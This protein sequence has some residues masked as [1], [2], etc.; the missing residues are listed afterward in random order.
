M[1]VGDDF[2]LNTERLR[3][4]RWREEDIDYA[5]MLWGDYRVTRLIDARGQLSKEQ[6]SER[7]A[8]EIETEREYAVQYWPVF[9]LNQDEFIG[10][11]GLRPYDLQDNIYEIG[12]HICA[13]HWGQGFA[14]EAAQAIISYAFNALQANSLF[15]GHNPNN[16]TSQR[17]LQKVGFSYTHDEYYKP[18]GL[19]HP[20]YKLTREQ[21]II[22]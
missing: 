3:F 8:K 17:L 20:S 18:T 21:V 22:D 15:A 9:L 12:F 4:R 6:V 19:Y 5:L 10:C 11:G 16:K 13:K 7:L 2:F 1:D 14:F